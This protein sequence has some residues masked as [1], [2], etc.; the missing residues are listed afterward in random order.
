MV[1]QTC[2]FGKFGQVCH[3]L[4]I[5]VKFIISVTFAIL[6]K[7]VTLGHYWT[8]QP[9]TASSVNNRQLSQQPSAQP[10]LS[11]LDTLVSTWQSHQHLPP[12][13]TLA[14]PGSTVSHSVLSIVLRKFAM[15]ILYSIL[16]CD[17]FKYIRMVIFVQDK[18]MYCIEYRRGRSAAAGPEQTT[19]E[20]QILIGWRLCIVYWGHRPECGVR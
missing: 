3:F 8:A 19:F 18:F 16:H 13:S 4:V 1:G 10:K 20:Y 2:L 5:T 15:S 9:T 17:T 11:A 12:L 7:I 6:V 14:A